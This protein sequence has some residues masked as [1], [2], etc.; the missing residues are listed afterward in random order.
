MQKLITQFCLIIT[1]TVVFGT[2][3]FAQLTNFSAALDAVA[4]DQDF[5][6]IF[7]SGGEANNLNEIRRTD[8]VINQA[9]FF[10]FD[11]SSV[12]ANSIVTS[13]ELLFTVFETPTS[14]GDIAIVAYE[15]D[16]TLTLPDD[17]SGPA[18]LV[19]SYDPVSLGRGTVSVELDASILGGFATTGGFVG[20]RMQGLENEAFTIIRGRETT[21]IGIAPTLALNVTTVPEPSALLPMLF[22]AM[23]LFAF[24]LRP[25]HISI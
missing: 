4:Q 23:L 10:E 13:A 22:A 20:I 5:N 14:P 1:I 8:G 18:L 6:G 12:A 11:V 3:S 7:E 17:G 9:Y 21:L 24:R 16:G 19:G 25:T 15:A 2:Q